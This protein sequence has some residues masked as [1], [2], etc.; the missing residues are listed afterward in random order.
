MRFP[1]NVICLST[2]VT[3][4]QNYIKKIIFYV[5]V[6]G[7]IARSFYKSKFTFSNS[8]SLCPKRSNFHVF[9]SYKFLSRSSPQT[10]LRGTEFCRR[11]VRSLGSLWCLQW[12]HPSL[13]GC[14]PYLGRLPLHGSDVK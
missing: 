14:L 11:E 1:K 3:A 4:L 5:I 10:E 8:T 13:V 9:H 12:V 6:S 7:T 2:E